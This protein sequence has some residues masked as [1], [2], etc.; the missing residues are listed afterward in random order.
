MASA[1]TFKHETT[2]H[3]TK[4]SL[5][6]S[7]ATRRP[8]A[9]HQVRPV[10]IQEFALI[11]LDPFGSFWILLLLEFMVYCLL[12]GLVIVRCC[13][14]WTPT[15]RCFAGRLSAGGE[16]LGPTPGAAAGELQRSARRAAGVRHHATME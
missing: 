11:L 15:S 16:R 7:L 13:F 8:D 14:V 3:T 12:V 6:Q 10:L 9:I 1:R 5:F 4:E 2:G